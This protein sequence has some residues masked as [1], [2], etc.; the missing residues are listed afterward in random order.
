MGIYEEAKIRITGL[1]NRVQRVYEA[2][3]TIEKDLSNKLA[4][5]KFKIM[6]GTLENLTNNF[7]VQLLIIIWNQG[8][9]I[10]DTD[11]LRAAF[12]DR[13]VGC[14]VVKLFYGSSIRKLLNVIL[15]STG[16]L[17][18]LCY[19]MDQWNPNLPNPNPKKS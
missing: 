17:Q 15:E 14:K 11:K 16:T 12:E 8:V 3:D 10:V 2:G 19:A 1:L 9:D 5:T 4:K 13:Y 18:N 7:E 6:Y